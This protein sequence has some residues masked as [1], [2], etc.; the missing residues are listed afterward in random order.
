MVA[1]WE[2]GSGVGEKAEGIKKYN[3]AVTAES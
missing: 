3:L 2:Q 1:R